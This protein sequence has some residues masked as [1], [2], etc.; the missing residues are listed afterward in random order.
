MKL[1]STLYPF[2]LMQHGA[3]HTSLVSSVAERARETL[4]GLRFGRPRTTFID[5]R[6]VRFTPWSTDVAALR[7]YTLGAQIMTPYDFAMAGVVMQHA[8]MARSSATRTRFP[9][10]LL[11][12]RCCFLCR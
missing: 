8:A 5:G 4:S 11:P 6:G 2:R 7:D 10:I 12:S 3:Y 1:G 9:A